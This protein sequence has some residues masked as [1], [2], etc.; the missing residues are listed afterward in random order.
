MQLNL[1]IKDLIIFLKKLGVNINLKGR[2]I[3]INESKI[4]NQN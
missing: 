2:T 3:T 4:K 1:K